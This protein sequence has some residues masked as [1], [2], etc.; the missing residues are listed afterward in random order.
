MHCELREIE[1]GLRPLILRV[2]TRPFDAEAADES[3]AVVGVVREAGVVAADIV[4]P[5]NLRPQS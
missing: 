5:T 3:S 1:G 2:G 4:S